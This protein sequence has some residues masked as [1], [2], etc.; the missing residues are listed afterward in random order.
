MIYIFSQPILCKDKI[1][2]TL[3]VSTSNVRP[4]NIELAV[5]KKPCTTNITTMLGTINVRI[6]TTAP[7]LPLFPKVA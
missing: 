4:I 1:A 3:G 6:S 5:C 2:F 7:S